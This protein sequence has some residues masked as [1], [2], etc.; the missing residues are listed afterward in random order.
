MKRRSSA[1][2]T[3]S[4]LFASLLFGTVASM[5]AGCGGNHDVASNDVQTLRSRCSTLVN[6]MLGANEAQVSTATVVPA[7]GTSPEY[8]AVNA[9]II[10]SQLKMQLNLPTD[11]WNGKLAFLGGGG[12]DGTMAAFN[13]SYNSASIQSEHYATMGTNGGYDYTEA[14]KYPDY[15]KAEFAT[16]PQQLADYTHLGD[17]RSL[18]FGKELI[19]RFYGA[20]PSKSYFEGCSMGGHDAMIEAQRYPDDFDGIVARAPAGNVMGLFMQFNR[21]AKAVRVPAGTL[22][23]AKQT[24]LA[25]AVLSQC[26]ELDGVKDGIISNPA[27]CKFDPTVLRCPGGGDTGDSCL[28]DTQIGTVQAITTSFATTDNAITHPGYNFGLENS[29]N[30]WGSYIWPQGAYGGNSLQGLFSDGFIRS[31]VTGDQ[32]YDT[33]QFDPNQWS[34][35]LAVIGGMFEAFDPDLSGLHSHGAKMVMMNGTNDTSVSPRDSARYYDSVVTK[36]GSA[37][38]DDTLEL[39][40]EPGVGHCF[41]GPGPD[42]V[43]LLKAVSTWAEG[44]PPPSQQRLTLTKLDGTGKSVLTRPLCKYPAYPHY[45]GSGSPDD[46]ASYSCST[47]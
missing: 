1:R 43:D 10:G 41:G 47:Q 28:S 37:S 45:N 34:A 44:G 26:D 2:V 3:R 17:H 9:Q 15:F 46:A 14:A 6:A 18:P 27:A 39:F 21:V 11:G 23:T 42:Q 40:L 31:F 12:F 4:E 22:N 8:C 32:N 33:S 29:A 38:T 13:A 19:Q 20:Q 16:D 35:R 7:S 30:G 24:L 25:N 36:M 5:L